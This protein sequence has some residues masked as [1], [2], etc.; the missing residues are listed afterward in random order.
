MA[1]DPLDLGGGRFTGNR[2]VLGTVN[3][4]PPLHELCQR[5][6]EDDAIK[7]CAESC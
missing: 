7:C 6:Y 4:F 5:H 3:Y 1:S 2:C